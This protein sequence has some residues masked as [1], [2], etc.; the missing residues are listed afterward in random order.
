MKSARSKTATDE[1]VQNIA[2]FRRTPIHSLSSL[3]SL[4][5]LQSSAHAPSE[6]N[7]RIESPLNSAL[8]LHTLSRRDWR[9]PLW[10]GLPTLRVFVA[11]M[12][13]TFGLLCILV[14]SFVWYEYERDVPR[15]IGGWA[16]FLAPLWTLYVLIRAEDEFHPT[17]EHSAESLLELVLA[18]GRP[19]HVCMQL[20]AEPLAVVGYRCL[21]P[22]S[23]LLLASVCSYLALSDVVHMAFGG[24]VLVFATCAS[25]LMFSLIA[26][27]RYELR[28]GIVAFWLFVAATYAILALRASPSQLLDPMNII[29]FFSSFAPSA[30]PASIMQAAY[31]WVFAGFAAAVFSWCLVRRRVFV[32]KVARARRP[33]RR[34]IARELALADIMRAA[35]DGD[36]RLG[37]DMFRRNSA[38][39]GYLL[40]GLIP[41]I[42]WL[43][44]LTVYE[45]LLA[46]RV[47]SLVGTRTLDEVRL[48]G[49]DAGDLGAGIREAMVREA[50]LATPGLAVALSA[51]ILWLSRESLVMYGTSSRLAPLAALL[52]LPVV[53]KLAG[54]TLSAISGA[55]LRY[56]PNP[57]S[58]HAAYF[59]VSVALLALSFAP[60]VFLNRTGLAVLSTVVYLA[61]SLIAALLARSTNSSKALGEWL[62]RDS[63]PKRF[64]IFAMSEEEKLL[65]GPEYLRH[66]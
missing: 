65:L 56:I 46:S 21:R 41:L 27:T 61:V 3:Q 42:G 53:W 20:L 23:L 37:R 28:V 36:A 16:Y 19:M 64:S 12:A 15:V 66:R 17:R 6:Q 38:I 48:V 62:E 1:P 35:L 10:T 52:L 5:S 45:W 54:K 9:D 29:Y 33:R 11:V 50:V 13:I 58:K 60:D 39:A 57:A 49:L 31:A 40:L 4:Q 25:Y 47:K 30:F 18:L 63:L 59:P 43:V 26:R 7:M 24:A 51:L 34:S 14:G 22:A 32:P 55:T 8:L 44:V 2:R